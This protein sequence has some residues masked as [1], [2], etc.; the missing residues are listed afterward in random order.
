MEGHPFHKGLLLCIPFDPKSAFN[1]R[2]KK[3]FSAIYLVACDGGADRCQ[4]HPN[5]VHPACDRP[6]FNQRVLGENPQGGKGGLCIFSFWTYPCR[7]VILLED[8]FI[9]DQVVKVVP[10]IGDSMIY[11]VYLA[12]LELQAEVA[13]SLRMPCNGKNT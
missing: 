7:T 8:C 9:Y 6:A 13:V 12:V 5:L 1:G 11:F 3:G 2:D 10:S 4:M